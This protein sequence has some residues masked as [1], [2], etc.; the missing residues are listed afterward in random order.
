MD[1][2]NR[3]EEDEVIGLAPPDDDLVKTEEDEASTADV[4]ASTSPLPAATT[5]RPRSS[6]PPDSVS[7]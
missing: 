7:S 2:S 4:L 3:M 5:D 1:S 6:N